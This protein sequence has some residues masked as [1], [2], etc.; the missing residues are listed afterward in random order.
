MKYPDYLNGLIGGSVVNEK[1][2]KSLLK[3]RPFLIKPNIAELSGMTGRQLDDP[4]EL[5]QVMK[6][7]HEQG[8]ANV[9]VSMGGDGAC[10]YDGSYERAEA[11]KGKVVSTIGSGDSMVAGFMY[12][13]E[14]GMNGRDKLKYATACGSA[15]A[16]KL[17]LADKQEVEDLFNSYGKQ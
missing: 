15:T 13:S 4:E 17:G 2:L 3:Y 11:F 14:Q 16:F 8:I 5:I 1:Y 6:D 10:L 7:I 12:A 9:L